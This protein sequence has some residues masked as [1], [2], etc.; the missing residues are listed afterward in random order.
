MAYVFVPTGRSCGE[1]SPRLVKRLLDQ[2][3]TSEWSARPLELKRKLEQRALEASL[4]S[5][6]IRRTEAGTYW[7]DE[8]KW[9]RCRARQMRWVVISIMAV[10]LLFAILYV[11]GEFS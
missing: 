4:K 11:L 1:A 6:M 9:S 5:G 10:L 2:G 7:V 8:E 3:A